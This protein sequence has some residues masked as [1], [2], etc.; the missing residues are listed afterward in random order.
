MILRAVALVLL[1]GGWVSADADSYR[2]VFGSFQEAANANR[3]ATEVARRLA[4][5]T[6]V[7]PF[8]AAGPRWHRVAT[9][10]LSDQQIRALSDRA[11]A[12]GLVFWR[13]KVA[14]KKSKKRN[15][16]NQLSELSD[17]VLEAGPS[18]AELAGT[19]DHGNATAPITAAATPLV[20]A[21]APVTTAQAGAA[22]TVAS[23]RQRYAPPRDKS[24]QPLATQRWDLDLGLQ[25]RTYTQGGLAGQDQFQPSLSAELQWRRSW[26][27]E[28]QQVVVT[29]FVRVDGIDDHRSHFDFR[30]LYWNW[31]GER[32]EVN[33][34]AKQEFWGVTEFHHLVDVVNQ[35]DLVENIDGEDKL[36]QPMAQLSVV[37]DWGIVDVFL[38]TGFRE[39]TFPSRDGR[40]RSTIAVDEAFT[41]YESGAEHRRFDGVIRW[42][43]QLGALDIGVYH[44]SGTSREPEFVP[45]L[46]GAGELFLAPHYPII[47]QTALDAQLTVADWA[48][49][50]EALSRSGFGAGQYFAANV[51]LEHT[52]VGVFGT[53]SD[54][55][56]VVEYMYDDRGDAA[57]NT[58]FENDVALGARWFMNDTQD[59]QALA[60]FIWDTETEEYI[61]SLEASRRLGDSWMLFLEGRVF[62]GGRAPRTD[63]LMAL[64]DPNNK[65]GFLQRD[66]LI[67]L[68]LTRYF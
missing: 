41:T 56:V 64:M 62:G 40:L 14:E 10:P 51:G 63:S 44:F 21:V 59:T 31:V 16:I 7:E 18:P 20:A 34:G 12:Q 39:R 48:F 6:R 47:E 29:P 49:K 23:L 30:E 24:R 28:R 43:N 32:W 2:L 27:D 46:D 68:E 60:G 17:P 54:L 55:G 52:L 61:L 26:H 50:L 38:L 8:E 67:Q 25:T 57:F 65:S 35:T 5:D 45:G 42:S 53:R 36:G 1:V 33:L 19:L 13:A 66:D 22:D 3:W 9:A 4:A 11:E 15:Y 58:L 37:R